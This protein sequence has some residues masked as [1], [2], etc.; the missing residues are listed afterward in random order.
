MQNS[1]KMVLDAFLVVFVTL[2][3][4]CRFRLTACERR[5]FR[6]VVV[7]RSPAQDRVGDDLFLF[8]GGV[9]WINCAT[10]DC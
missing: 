2:R 4:P 3:V 6:I 9:V 7:T 10:V 1:R 8:R 5:V